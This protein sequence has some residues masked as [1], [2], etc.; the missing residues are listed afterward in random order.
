MKFNNSAFRIFGKEMINRVLGIIA[1][2]S[3]R[4]FAEFHIN[5]GQLLLLYWNRT[6]SFLVIRR[7]LDCK[8]QTVNCRFA[9]CSNLPDP[10]TFHIQPSKCK[11]SLTLLISGFW[12]KR[13]HSSLTPI[14]LFDLFIGLSFRCQSVYKD[15]KKNRR[16]LSLWQ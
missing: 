10:S 3:V 6:L 16:S 2:C 9:G 7:N 14:F 15:D 11:T 8:N 5:C 4:S 12:R 13:F 1:R